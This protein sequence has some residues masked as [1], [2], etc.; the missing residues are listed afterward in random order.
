MLLAAVASC[1]AQMKSWRLRQLERLPKLV[2][3]RTKLRKETPRLHPP[4]MHTFMHRFGISIVSHIHPRSMVLQCMVV[5]GY[6]T[7]RTLDD[8]ANVTRL[9]MSRS[10]QQHSLNLGGSPREPWRQIVKTVGQ[11]AA[12]E[13]LQDHQVSL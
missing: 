10:C 9:F 8:V 4:F 1:V 6:G 11:S 2:V 5:S 3:L 7:A 13:V 12:R